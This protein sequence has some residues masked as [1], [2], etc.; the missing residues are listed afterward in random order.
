MSPQTPPAYFIP[1]LGPIPIK[2]ENKQMTTGNSTNRMKYL[3][4]EM[5]RKDAIKSSKP[6]VGLFRGLRERSDGKG[7]DAKNIKLI[8]LGTKGKENDLMALNLAVFNVLSIKMMY[9]D[10]KELIVFKNNDVDQGKAIELLEVAL[11]EFQKEKRM[12][13]N[14]PEIVDIKTFENVPKEFF[15]PQKNADVGNNYGYGVGGGMYGGGGGTYQGNNNSDWKKKQEEREA[16]KERQEKL[17]QT[18]ST[19][20]RTSELPSLKVLNAIKKK[21]AAIASGEYD[22]ALVDPD[23]TDTVEEKKTAVK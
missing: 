6:E 2:E 9:S 3:G 18:P 14:D 16:E 4:V 11:E 19:I 7:V 15:A 12:V 21:V 23:P 10:T 13:D 20:K 22:N 5:L 8:L 1:G 17:R